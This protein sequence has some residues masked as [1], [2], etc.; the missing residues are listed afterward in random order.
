MEPH[1]FLS[2]PIFYKTCPFACLLSHNSQSDLDS[3]STLL[4]EI[5]ENNVN[6]KSPY[7]NLYDIWEH[8][9]LAK[10]SKCKKYL[11]IVTQDFYCALFDL[12]KKCASI[13]NFPI[14]EAVSLCNVIYDG[15][16]VIF[17]CIF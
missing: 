8:V 3:I 17:G 16:R 13:I 5:F 15:Q 10:P 12:N 4:N 9:L 14:L 6:L 11:V 7:N 1:I 2:A